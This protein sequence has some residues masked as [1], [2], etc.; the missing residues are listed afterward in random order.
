MDKFINSLENGLDTVIGK[1]GI[2]L[3]GG[4]K[5]RLSIARLLLSKPKV[6]IFDEA[7]SALDN[8]TEYDLYKTLNNHIKG[9]TTLII[10]HRTTTIKQ[11]DYIYIIEQGHIKAKGTYKELNTK[12]FI[13]DDFD[14]KV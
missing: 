13:K 11:A 1:N 10:A 14:K 4:Q 2:K 9:I 7:T 3:S 12:G 6:L 8:Q 5:Q